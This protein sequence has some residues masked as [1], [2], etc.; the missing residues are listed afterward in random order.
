[1]LLGEVMKVVM[2]WHCVLM[3]WKVSHSVAMG[4]HCSSLLH[5][6]G[7]PA[8]ALGTTLWSPAQERRG[9]VGMS[10]EDATKIL[11]WLEH[12]CSRDSVGMDAVH[13]GEDPGETLQ[14]LPVPTGDLQES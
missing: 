3:A 13:P 4:G 5:S 14:P 1:M 11:R 10:P 7:T 2:S 6:C 9:P 8:G 12:L